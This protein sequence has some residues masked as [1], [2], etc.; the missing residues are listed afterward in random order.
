MASILFFALGS[1]VIARTAL[2]AVVYATNTRMI[3]SWDQLLVSTFG[4]THSGVVSDD[5]PDDVFMSLF[6]PPLS[7]NA[8]GA[9]NPVPFLSAVAMWTDENESKLFIH[10]DVHKFA[11]SEPVDIVWFIRPL[12]PDSVQVISNDFDSIRSIDETGEFLLLDLFNAGEIVVFDVH[13]L[14]NRDRTRWSRQTI[15]MSYKKTQT[16]SLTVKAFPATYLPS[17]M[18][19]TPVQ[20]DNLAGNTHVKLAPTPLEFRDF[21][22]ST[23]RFRFFTSSECAGNTFEVHTNN[24]GMWITGYSGDHSLLCVYSFIETI[25]GHNRVR[26]IE[27]TIGVFSVGENSSQLGLARSKLVSLNEQGMYT[28]LELDITPDTPYTTNS[29]VFDVIGA[30]SFNNSNISVDMVCTGLPEPFPCDPVSTDRVVDHNVFVQ[31]LVKHINSTLPSRD[32]FGVAL[33]STTRR[34]WDNPY[35]HLCDL[36]T[37]CPF[38]TTDSGLAIFVYRVEEGVGATTASSVTSDEIVH[39]ETCGVR[40]PDNV[41]RRRDLVTVSPTHSTTAVRRSTMAVI[42]RNGTILASEYVHPRERT[43][44]FDNWAFHPSRIQPQNN[45]NLVQAFP[46]T[47]AFQ[48]NHGLAIDLVRVG[49]SFITTNIIFSASDDANSC[50]WRLGPL[51]ISSTRP[52]DYFGGIIWEHMTNLTTRCGSPTTAPPLTSTT[53]PAIPP[54]ES[55]VSAPTSTPVIS[56][57]TSTT[58]TPFPST[59]STTPSSASPTTTSTTPSSASPT[60][61]STAPTSASP[62]VPLTPVPSTISTA[63]PSAPPTTA[64]SSIVTNAPTSAQQLPTT[65]EA[66]TMLERVGGFMF[67]V[68]IMVPIGVTTSVLV[69]F[70]LYA[71][72]MFTKHQVTKYKRIG[73]RNT[74][75]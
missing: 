44:A 31:G 57:P 15:G 61:T 50:D 28:P 13:V 25:E 39:I 26:G 14:E 17:G 35:A 10:V 1:S 5:I 49:S 23:Q 64:P 36:E 55:P 63:P 27:R 24:T 32:R 71:S 40:G 34:R 22:E 60:T 41:C 43:R 9:S 20:R 4:S 58:T 12:S 16:P 19:Y 75:D 46:Q 42:M 11:S 45:L 2:S 48:T 56:P 37:A 3:G 51:N 21:V 33:N 53:P 68:W 65:E 72:A 29:I 59:T 6:L 73:S 67:F 62:T 74:R 69:V 8:S 52:S 54:S 38:E 30:D 66:T 47:G 70:F 18:W 7:W